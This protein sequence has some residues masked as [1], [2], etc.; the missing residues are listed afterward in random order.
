MG[1]ENGFKFLSVVL[2]ALLSYH[3]R[4]QPDPTS[5]SDRN[6]AAEGDNQTDILGDFSPVEDPEEQEN[7]T[8]DPWNIVDQIDAI[9]GDTTCDT[10]DLRIQP[11]DTST[12]VKRKEDLS[13]QPRTSNI[14]DF[15]N[16]TEGAA[17]DQVELIV[18]DEDLSMN[19]T[20]DS[21]VNNS[22]ILQNTMSSIMN[23][24]S[25]SMMDIQELSEVQCTNNTKDRHRKKGEL[26]FVVVY[27]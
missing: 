6:D 20:R 21:M 19:T 9:L 16:D 26:Y 23:T 24:S 12:P 15:D 11:V 25:D 1:N 4:A 13:L 22:L 3:I 5:S 8:G 17:I 2:V 7:E 10:E 18:Q 27:N 14:F